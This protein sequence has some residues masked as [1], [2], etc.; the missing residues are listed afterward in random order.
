MILQSSSQNCRLRYRIEQMELQNRT[1]IF[2]RLVSLQPGQLTL[3]D[4]SV[5]VMAMVSVSV[6]AQYEL[7]TVGDEAG[8]D[9]MH[10]GWRGKAEDITH[11][12]E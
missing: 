2:R 3:V 10:C 8:Y 1:P 12:S 11:E 4:A 9:L 7:M 6:K 5:T